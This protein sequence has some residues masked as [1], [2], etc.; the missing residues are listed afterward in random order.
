[1]IDNG[2]ENAYFSIT[3]MVKVHMAK[4]GPCNNAPNELLS[5]SLT[6]QEISRGTVGLTTARL[7]TYRDGLSTPKKTEQFLTST[8][9]NN[10]IAGRHG[11][12]VSL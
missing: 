5:G 4:N 7:L 6:P 1:V 9:V 3:Y 12:E 11:V 2:L 8:S 10:R